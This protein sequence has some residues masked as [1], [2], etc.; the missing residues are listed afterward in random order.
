MAIIHAIV[1][2]FDSAINITDKQ[3]NAPTT[4]SV[5]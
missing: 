2:K 1:A 5:L 4:E 3:S